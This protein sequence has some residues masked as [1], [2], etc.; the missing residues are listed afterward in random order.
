MLKI[1]IFFSLLILLNPI[2]SQEKQFNNSSLF[3]K[4]KNLQSKGD[5]FYN[6]GL[7]PTKRYKRNE[8]LKKEDNNIFFTALIVFTLQSVYDSFSI[9]EKKIADTIINKAVQ[10]YPRYSNRNGD[11]TYN[12]WQT[13]PDIFFPNDKYLSKMEKFK[14]PDDLDDAVLIF[15]TKSK[16][17][18]LN[19]L[20]KEKM[21]QHTNLYNKQIKSTFKRYRNYKAYNTW[22]SEK[23]PLEFDICVMANVLYFVFNKGFELNKFDNETIN[24]IGAMI[25]NKDH[26]KN[27]LIISTSYQKSSIILYHL[28]R[29]LSVSKSE[30]LNELKPQIIS[31]LKNILPDTE[32]KFEQI[33]ILSS[34]YRLGENPEFIVDFAGI[35]EEITNFVFFRGNMLA[36]SKLGVRKLFG[37]CK[38]VNYN[39]QCEAYYY[40][41]IL[42]YLILKKGIF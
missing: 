42:E 18:S 40:A 14:L 9:N 6:E 36:L 19:I 27:P 15:L 30:K 41:L 4:I 23:M 25:E 35:E 8:K 28:A 32:S 7:F 34:L 10:N 11:I 38:F 13:K 39:H 16:N 2:F 33:L 26:L 12:F 31:D 24:L 3:I 37:K 5:G 17:D 22:F 21:I 29:L 20:L 1:T